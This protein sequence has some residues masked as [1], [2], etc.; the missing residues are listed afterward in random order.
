V[1]ITDYAKSIVSY[2]TSSELR[3][4]I[5]QTFLPNLANTVR[6]HPLLK[7]H[8]HSVK[9]RSKD[10]EHLL[11]KLLRKKQ[12]LQGS[13][14]ITAD[15]LFRKVNDLAGLRVLHLY[16]RQIADID[17]ALKTMFEESHYK[18]TEGPFARTWDDE[19]RDYFSDLGIKIEKSPTLYT[20]VH[21][22]IAPN[23]QFTCEIQV[24]TLMEE[25]WGEIDHAI[26]Y[27]DPSDSVA[28]QEQL[29]ALA[30]ATS[31]CSRLV[32]SIVASHADHI[33]T[34]MPR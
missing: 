24:R 12:K 14:R 26:N 22:V 11:K 18:I 21:Y 29:R 6:T 19:S 3:T 25:V 28:C 13:K 33:A 32:D 34:E 1:S 17:A 31:S 23:R 8:V 10:P 9:F 20:S 27:P 5:E 2:Y 30:R 4:T 15:N 16:T 7:P